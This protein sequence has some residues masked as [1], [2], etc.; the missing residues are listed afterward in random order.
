ML[1]NRAASI[2]HLTR[3]EFQAPGAS[4]VLLADDGDQLCDAPTPITQVPHPGPNLVDR[5]VWSLIEVVPAYRRPPGRE[6]CRRAE[7]GSPGRSSAYVL[8]RTAPCGTAGPTTTRAIARP[9]SSRRWAAVLLD[10]LIQDS[11][12]H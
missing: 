2:L 7:G 12:G 9:R 10:E 5:V 6:L 8:R 11:P 1:N 3:T 4:R